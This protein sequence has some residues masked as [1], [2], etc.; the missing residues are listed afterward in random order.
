[1]SNHSVATG[2]GAILG[3]VIGVTIASAT[4]GSAM[5]VSAPSMIGIIVGG[6]VGA[7]LA[8]G[9]LPKRPPPT[10]KRPQAD[11]PPRDES[12]EG[13]TEHKPKPPRPPGT[14]KNP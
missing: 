5:L 7:M 13:E 12:D 9:L 14:I 11:E 4:A 3:A 8:Y 6:L 10:I 1:M 2:L